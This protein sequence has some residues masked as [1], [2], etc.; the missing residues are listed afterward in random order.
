MVSGSSTPL[1]TRTLRQELDNW[2]QSSWLN[3]IKCIFSQ[4]FTLGVIWIEKLCHL[5]GDC[6]LP[7]LLFGFHCKQIKET[8]CC[9]VAKSCPTLQPH[10]LQNTRLL[11]P[12]LSH[13]VCSNSHPLSRWCYLTISSSS[14]TSSFC[15]QSFPASGSVSALCIRWAKYWSLSFSI[16]PSNECSGLISFRIDC[17]DLLAAQGTLKSLLQHHRSKASILR[18]SAFFMVQVSHSYVATGKT[19][20][21]TIWP[22]SIKWCLSFLISCLVCHS[23][24][25]KE[26]A[27]LNVMAALT[28]H[29]DFGAQ[30]N[31]ICHCFHFSPICLPW[32]SA[33][34]C[35]EFNFWNVE[36]WSPFTTLLFHPHQ[37]TV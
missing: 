26:Q 15:L 20:A 22:L 32:S 3:S 10:G 31:E 4:Y 27:S 6:S 24:P 5:K 17:F 25:S 21:L 8:C 29:T 1:Q 11:C 13:G 12:P 34:G 30:E 23:F 16:S 33:T 19:I 28:V 7:G 37:E 9:S 2:E 14:A 36:F 18:C 35:H